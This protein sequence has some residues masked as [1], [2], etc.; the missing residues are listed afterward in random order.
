[1]KNNRLLIIIILIIIL[2]IG[3]GAYFLF[4]QNKI[5]NENLTKNQIQSKNE[6]QNQNFNENLSENK[7]SNEKENLS[8]NRNLNENKSENENNFSSN[9]ISENNTQ[10]SVDII[11]KTE[12]ISSFSTKIYTKEPERQNNVRL[13]CSALN[14]TIVKN[15]NTFSFCSILGPATPKKGYQKA[16]IF[17][18]KR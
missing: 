15:D 3:I 4:R 1:M 18:D 2:G 5:K 7:K 12:E 11:P 16:D 6:I 9:Y 13:T 17:D 8:L 14:G 10:K